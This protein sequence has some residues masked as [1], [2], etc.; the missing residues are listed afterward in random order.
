MGCPDCG[1]CAL[2]ETKEADLVCKNCGLVHQDGLI[3]Y[4]GYCAHTTRNNVFFKIMH[5][6]ARDSMQFIE[7]YY[8]CWL[9]DG[10]LSQVRGFF[11]VKVHELDALQNRVANMKEQCAIVVLSFY[12]VVPWMHTELRIQEMTNMVCRTIQSRSLD[13]FYVNDLGSKLLIMM[14]HQMK[15]IGAQAKAAFAAA[16]A[17]TG[18][19]AEAKAKAKAKAKAEAKAEAETDA[20]AEAEAVAVAPGGNDGSKGAE[21]NVVDDAALVCVK[22]ARQEA[23]VPYTI[24]NRVQ[25]IINTV[26]DDLKMEPGTASS[27]CYGI[28]CM[29]RGD[30]M[31]SGDAFYIAIIAV[32][33]QSIG[34]SQ[35]QLTD[36]LRSTI[37]FKEKEV[38]QCRNAITTVLVRSH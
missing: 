6:N 5:P 26:A 21:T 33:L 18:A 12:S 30:V 8:S 34:K 2:I 9:D 24:K 37:V 4:E 29:V 20:K 25:F 13:L 32:F 17:A 31:D 28:Y 19:K 15:L 35:K 10:I 27:K 36:L 14:D 23:V 22:R 7:N 16:K 38:T 11:H 3:D 1:K